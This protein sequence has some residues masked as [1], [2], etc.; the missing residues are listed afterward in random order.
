MLTLLTAATSAAANLQ[1]E[2][3]T[4][5]PLSILVKKPVS[6]KMTVGDGVDAGPDASSDAPPAAGKERD[7][8]KDGP[9]ISR[10]SSRITE[11]HLHHAERARSM[12]R[13]LEAT[14]RTSTPQ[15]S[16]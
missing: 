5:A 13:I 14:R 6:T 9:A 7:G 16:L 15:G 2:E 8:T 4:E 10:G 3:Q 1:E 11:N 12:I